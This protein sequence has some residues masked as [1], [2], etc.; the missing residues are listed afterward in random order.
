V[1][2][3]FDR[4]LTPNRRSWNDAA[5][6]E[7]LYGPKNRT[8]E[9]EMAAV[10]STIGRTA[11]R[12]EVRPTDRLRLVRDAEFAT[13]QIADTRRSAPIHQRAAR[14]RLGTL[15]AVCG[16]VALWFGT[17]ALAG[18]PGATPKPSLSIASGR[19][20]VVRSG[21]TLES[22]A[23]SLVPRRDVSALMGSL[24][25]QLHGKV[26]RPGTVLRVP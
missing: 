3:P 8:R 11:L 6:T 13:G 15:A 18:T 16:L 5:G 21:D 1:E 10:P 23:Q 22:I 14:R 17:G 12:Q 26:L 25:R 24:A 4:S 2:H 19:V 7:H 20:Y 9:V